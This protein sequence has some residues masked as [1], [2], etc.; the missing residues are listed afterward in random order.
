MIFKREDGYVVTAEPEMVAIAARLRHDIV[1]EEGLFRFKQNKLL[2]HLMDNGAFYIPSNANGGSGG[3]RLEQRGTISLHSLWDDYE[4]GN[5]SLAELM[6]F[7]MEIGYS[8]C[9]FTEMF[10]LEAID[11]VI[12]G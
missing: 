1:Y 4:S 6:K 5:F 7:Y 9:G 12:K 3:N 10:G 8:W 2:R 11:S